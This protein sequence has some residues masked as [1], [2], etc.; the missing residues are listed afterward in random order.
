MVY[1]AYFIQQKINFSVL[2]KIEF[3]IL[4]VFSKYENKISDKICPVKK[5]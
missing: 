3:L 2:N 1:F 5:K 4:M